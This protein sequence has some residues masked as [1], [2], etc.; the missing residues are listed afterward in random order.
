MIIDVQPLITVLVY[1]FEKGTI[2]L[3]NRNGTQLVSVAI[4]SDRNRWDPDPALEKEQFCQF[5]QPNPW[6]E[7][8]SSFVFDAP[9][10]RCRRVQSDLTFIGRD[11]VLRINSTAVA[12]AG[13]GSSSSTIACSYWPLERPRGEDERVTYGAE[14]PL[15]HTGVYLNVDMVAVR[16]TNW[17]GIAIYSDILIHPRAL[18]PPERTRTIIEPVNV[19]AFGIDSMSRLNFMRQLPLTYEYLAR[20]MGATVLRGMTRVGDNTFPNLV[21]ILTGLADVERPPMGVYFDSWPLVWKNFSQV[22]YATLLA[23]DEPQFT[24]FNYASS[25]FYEQPTDHYLR[26][27]YVAIDGHATHRLSS[28][29]CFGSRPKYALHSDFVKRF[30]IDSCETNRSFFAVSFLTEISHNLLN[31]V[32]AADRDFRRLLSDLRTHL[33]DTVLVFFGDHGHRFDEIRMT[34][35]G[36]VESSMPFFAVYLPPRLKR[37][38][39]R[40]ER[41]LRL[42]ARRLTSMFDVYETFLDIFRHSALGRDLGDESADSV[43]SFGTSLFGPIAANRTCSRAGIAPQFC[44]CSSERELSADDERSTLAADVVVAEINSITSPFRSECSVLTLGYVRNSYLVSDKDSE[45][46]KIRVVLE[47]EPGRG[48][49]EGFVEYSADAGRMQKVLGDIGRINRYDGQDKCLSR[50]MRANK[51]DLRNFCYCV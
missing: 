44:T 26:P 29:L 37:E 25:G 23:E 15:V 2:V 27:F 48:V 18:A 16:C 7:S 20:D 9:P 51:V 34:P 8:I 31:R 45:T 36:R 24:V 10:I 38:F 13:Y 21:A 40:A 46:D 5:P 42:N 28:N 50:S 32:G 47:T 33:N 11:H 22:G 19:L 12:R 1:S 43:S 14:R 6:D 49:F 35:I 3:T 30:V 39:P 17:L 4:L 41:N